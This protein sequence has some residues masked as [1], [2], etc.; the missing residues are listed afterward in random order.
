MKPIVSA[1]LNRLA[2][3]LFVGAVANAAALPAHSAE[4]SVWVSTNDPTHGG[5]EDF[6]QLFDPNAPWQAARRHVAV[7]SIDQNLV[8]N[9][10]PDK[11]RKL[12]GYVAGGI[13]ASR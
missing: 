3:L 9:G 4:P 7:F 2:I 8:T 1:I 13:H 10:P 5:A 11:L 12:F 6:W